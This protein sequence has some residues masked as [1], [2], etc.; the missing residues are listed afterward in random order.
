MTIKVS[1][2]KND[3]MINRI[4]GENDF[5]IQDLLY[6]F[7]QILSSDFMMSLMLR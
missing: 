3:S 4:S 2:D 1:C 7:V 5:L 6:Y